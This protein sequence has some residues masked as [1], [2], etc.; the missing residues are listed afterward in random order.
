MLAVPWTQKLRP[1][2]DR[3]LQRDALRG[4]LPEKTRQR[5][6]KSGA[7]QAFFDGL[8]RNPDWVDFLTTRCHLVER[9]YLDADQWRLAVMRARH[10]I[11]ACF[12]YFLT[13]CILE[14]WF[15]ML[16]NAPK[17]RSVAILASPP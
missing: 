12:P 9:G 2:Q 8:N 1:N 4:I 17:P 3:W 10:G 6:G 16:S 11:S 7:D 14:T 13:A 5:R 15:K